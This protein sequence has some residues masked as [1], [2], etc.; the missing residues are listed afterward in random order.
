MFE[1]DEKIMGDYVEEK[2]GPNKVK[3]LIIVVSCI[4]LL[5][6]LLAFLGYFNG[7]KVKTK[8]IVSNGTV[9]MT[10][11]DNSNGIDISDSTPISDKDGMALNGENQYFD[12]TVKSSMD[13]DAQIVYE[14]A[15]TK[16][17][18]STLDGKNIKI[19]LEKE[20]NGTYEKVS[21]P[22]VY[23]PLLR[24]SLIGTPA[25]SMVINKVVCKNDCNDNYRLRMWVS[26]NAQL[27]ESD[28]NFSIKVNIYAK[29]K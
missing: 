19:Y 13:G 1:E 9:S 4:I 12:F 28:N 22:K 26:Q 14:I 20:N 29:A 8:T 3:I 11:T 21:D 18:K 7:N 15:V 23:S 25:G 24:K 2:K 5:I 16:E 27:K 6:I 17:N 10:Y